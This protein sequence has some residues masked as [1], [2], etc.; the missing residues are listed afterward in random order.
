M[1]QNKAIKWEISEVR[2][3]KNL[4]GSLPSEKLS[5]VFKRSENAIYHKAFK[6]GL[7][8]L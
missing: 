8:A 5:K 3:L 4:Y 2:K 7:K 6:L 1:E